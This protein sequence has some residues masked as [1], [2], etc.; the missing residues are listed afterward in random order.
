MQIAFHLGAHCTDED[1]LLRSLLKNRGTLEASGIVLPAQKLYR[2][3][4][5]RVAKSL[6]GTVFESETR[7][8]I[9]DA[10]LDDTP[11]ERLVFSHDSLLAFPANVIGA[12]G[13]YPTAPQRIATY[14]NLFPGG[15][16]EFF[17]ALRN[18]ATL[19]PALVAR[20]APA[21]YAAVVGEI[22]PIGL[23][24]APVVRRILT[25]V[26]E[27]NLTLWCNEDT[28]LIWPELLRALAGVGSEDVLDGDF[29]LLAM[30]MTAEGLEKLKAFL[31][32][33]PPASVDQR[34]RSVAAFL[35]KYAHKDEMEIEIDM[36]GWTEELVGAMTEAYDADCAEIASIPGVEFILP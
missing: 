12:D 11:A 10:V 1:R 19:V 4:L 24:W 13:L 30:L 29:D 5:P 9:L 2:K 35:D 23:R 21:S 3:L 28:P 20:L 22:S 31:D 18:P 34:R 6:R 15:Q 32:T 36:P 27:V 33:H 14:A 8:V 26:P 17:L 25:Q 16:T 7:Q